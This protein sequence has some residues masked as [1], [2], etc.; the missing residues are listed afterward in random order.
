MQSKI[1]NPKSKI[2]DT[3]HTTHDTLH[4]DIAGVRTRILKGGSGPPLIYWHGAGCG[5]AWHPHHTLLAEHFTVYAPDHP[6]W[7]GS[8]NPEW[9]DIQDFVLHYDAVFRTL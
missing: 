5:M 3:R 7:G 8:D 1:H 4:L 6:G 2:D 9:D